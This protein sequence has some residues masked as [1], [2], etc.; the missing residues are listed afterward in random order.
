MVES[1]VKKMDDQLRLTGYLFKLCMIFTIQTMEARLV[2]NLGITTQVLEG[3]Q[4][5]LAALVMTIVNV[6]ML[7]DE[8]IVTGEKEHV[9]HV[10][11]MAPHMAANFCPDQNWRIVDD[12]LEAH[13]GWLSVL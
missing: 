9:Y 2:Y 1:T 12:L 3:L 13:S 10:A 6:Q 5:R 8:A 11:M 4:R 7:T